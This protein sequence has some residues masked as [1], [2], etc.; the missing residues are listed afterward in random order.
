MKKRYIFICIF[1]FL[2]I[3]NTIL[4]FTNSYN[5]FD[6]NVYNFIISF[7]NN[8]LDTFFKIITSLVNPIGV[9]ITILILLIFLNKEN[10]YR[11]LFTVSTTVIVNQALKHILR[12]VRPHHLRLVEENGFSYPS[13][14]SMIV[15]ALYGLLIYVVY[16]HIKNNIIKT[17]L[18]VLLSILIL[19][20]GISR[21]YLG[22]H[23]P[24]D[25]IGGYL[26]S[27]TILLVV[28]S[29]VNHFRGNKNDKDSSV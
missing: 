9:I 4:V 29:I 3:I 16:K 20:I 14:H 6:T 26:I 25:I 13:G 10:I 15:I 21:I 5:S 27:I 28:Y 17:I 18:I 24:T 11:L 8:Y 7:R 19:L 2:F 23:Y 12:R 22:V 1:F